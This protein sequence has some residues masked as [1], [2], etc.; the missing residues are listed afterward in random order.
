MTLFR[1]SKYHIVIVSVYVFVCTYFF[2]FTTSP[3]S[4]FALHKNDLG[5]F[6]LITICSFV[7]LIIANY[8]LRFG[9]LIVHKK[10]VFEIS[11]IIFYASILIA[12]PEEIIFRGF[13]QKNLQTLFQNTGLVIVFSAFIFGGAHVLN[14]AKNFWPREWNWKL[15]IMTCIAGFFLGLAYSITMSLVIPIILHVIFV[16]ALKIFIRE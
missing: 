11:F 1:L 6:F 3:A 16:I 13:I 8:F 4:S 9:R 2:F 12:L 7:S 14:G 5:I 15:V 10:D